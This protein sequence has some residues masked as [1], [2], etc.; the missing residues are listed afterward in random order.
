ME[1]HIYEKNI[2]IELKNVN[3]YNYYLAINNNNN[4]NTFNK[5]IIFISDYFDDKKNKINNMIEQ[6][7]IGIKLNAEYIIINYYIFETDIDLTK[8]FDDLNINKKYILNPEL[9]INNNEF[10]FIKGELLLQIYTNDLILKMFIKKNNNK[11]EL[12]IY[13][14]NDIKNKFYF[15]NFILKN[16]YSCND[17]K[18]IKYIPGYDNS[19]ECL[20]EWNIIYN[21]YNKFHNIS[22]LKK[23]TNKL[24]KINFKLE[25]LV[26]KSFL[27]CKYNTI[28]NILILTDKSDYNKYIK[29]KTWANIIKLYIN[30]S[31]N[32][33]KE[34]ILENK[35][36]I[37]S[38]KKIKKSIKYL[39]KYY[40]KNLFYY[41]LSL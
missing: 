32:N 35:L 12:D 19:L 9:K 39:D 13:N 4:N 38:K 24:F 15:Y 6:V 37:L 33:Q 31:I 10:I 16:N 21:Y 1:W 2:N 5:K 29:L 34:F 17:N 23:I 18:Y 22:N 28:K 8:S 36:N 30:I 14:I 11:Y 25:K 41:K 40:D 3:I 27:M 7:N 20:I 26:K